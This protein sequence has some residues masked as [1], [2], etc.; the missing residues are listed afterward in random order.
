MRAANLRAL[1]LV[2]VFSVAITGSTLGKIIY[3]DDDAVGANNGTSWADAY[4]YLQDALADANSA[5]KPVEI[6]VAQGIYK[7][8]QGANQT[9]GDRTATFQLINGVTLKGGYAGVRTPD[10]N[11]RDI[12][13]YETIL[14]GDLADNDVS[15]TDPCDL[16][17]E[18]TRAENCYNILTAKF[19][20][21]TAVLD[22]FIVSSGNAI[23]DQ[24]QLEQRGAGLLVLGDAFS[25]SCPSILNCTFV[26]NSA[27][28]GGAVF[29][30][31]GYPNLMQCRFMRNAA[32]HGGALLNEAVRG[33]GLY[34][35][36]YQ[37]SIKKCFFVSNYAVETGGGMC[38]HGN[39]LIIDGTFLMNNIAGTGGAIHLRYGCL[40]VTNCLLVKNIA[41]EVGGAMYFVWGDLNITCC[42]FSGNAAENGEAVACLTSWD[43]DKRVI[44][45]ATLTNTILWDGGDEIHI[46][47]WIEV[48][49]KYSNIQSGLEGE[50]IG[51]I[52]ADPLFANPGYWDPNGTPTDS[53]DDFWVE[54]DY[55]L[56]SQADRWDQKTQTW[57][58]DDVTS[59]CIDVGDP[60]SPIGHEP[61]PNGGR[62]NMGAYGGTAE[63]S[64]SYFG[65]PPCETIVAGDINGDCKVDFL[66]LA[67]LALHWLEER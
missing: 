62:I 19:C 63:A 65:K 49:I 61:F 55:H 17:T 15:T 20:S 12:N 58:A 30:L 37:L 13:T 39:N 38:I 35:P 50:Y 18:P 66:D 64:K 28:Q 9:A 47:D 10:P 3:V 27:Y 33:I 48:V 57:G 53:N 26:D 29:I 23:G 16:L 56:K 67:I 45:S 25:P 60:N 7:P 51:N 46:S 24:H 6:L 1:V 36:D 5:E 44:S 59:P 52:D 40:N 42:T 4:V 22:G 54:G 11:A 21:R 2:A 14:S 41:C 43:E 32:T 8:D 31:G 34:E